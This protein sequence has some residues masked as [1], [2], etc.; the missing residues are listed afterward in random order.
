MNTILIFFNFSMS[1]IY[2]D[3]TYFKRL[4]GLQRLGRRGI[5]QRKR[6]TMLCRTS[7]LMVNQ[8]FKT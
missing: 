7:Y 1:D 6:L 8:Q 2:Y 4:I 5:F 3:K